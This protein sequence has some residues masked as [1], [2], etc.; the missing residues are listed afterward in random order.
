MIS[1]WVRGVSNAFCISFLL[2]SLP[3]LDH[4]AGV[5]YLKSSLYPIPI[6]R[7]GSYMYR[8]QLPEGI[9]ISV[10]QKGYP[11]FLPSC[12]HDEPRNM[13]L[14]LVNLQSY[15]YWAEGNVAAH[16]VVAP[17]GQQTLRPSLSGRYKCMGD[18]GVTSA[19]EYNLYVIGKEIVNDIY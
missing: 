7:I 6:G 5:V 18:N 10:L 9:N 8:A 3:F 17:L 14:R 19:N 4:S 1:T 16:G 15:F 2:C 12:E 13:N 11:S